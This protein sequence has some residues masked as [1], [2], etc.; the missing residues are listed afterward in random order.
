MLDEKAIMREFSDCSVLALPSVQETAPMV[1]AQAMA[2]AKPVVATF[3]GGIAEMVRDG[4]TG[5]LVRKGDTN[6]LSDS[7]LKVSLLALS[8]R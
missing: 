1:I 5:I 6:S 4:E 7:L 8:F 2:A 3:V